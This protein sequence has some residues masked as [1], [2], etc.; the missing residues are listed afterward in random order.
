MRRFELDLGHSIA[1]VDLDTLR[2]VSSTADVK[3]KLRRAAR[4][5]LLNHVYHRLKVPYFYWFAK[6]QPG[7]GDIHPGFGC[8]SLPSDPAARIDVIEEVAPLLIT[9]SLHYKEVGDH[10]SLSAVA[11]LL[12][13]L[14][15]EHFP[16][17]VRSTLP[18]I[19]P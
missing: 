4:Y 16:D 1:V 5:A 15:A 19:V 10:D 11:T 18:E 13:E 12:K 6:T 2:D 14:P 9:L 7:G 17:V 3:K 8:F